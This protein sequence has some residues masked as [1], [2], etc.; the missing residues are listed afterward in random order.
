MR[1]IGIRL[2]A[3]LLMAVVSPVAAAHAAAKAAPAAVT[4]DQRDKGMAAAPGLVSAAGLDCQVADA[5]LVGE[6]KDPKTKA[7]TTLYELACTGNLGVIVQKVGDAAPVAYTCIQFAEPGPDGKP[8]TTQCILPGNADPKAGLV[9]Y[10]AKAGKIC[11]LDKARALGQS[12]TNDVF[13]VACK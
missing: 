13:E 2:A 6:A 9:P 10:I 1:S 5:R 8:N 7:E 11:T 4:K 3:I 12:T